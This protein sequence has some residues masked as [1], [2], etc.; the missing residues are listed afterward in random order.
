MFAGLPMDLLNVEF[1]FKAWLLVLNCAA[2]R[3]C[4]NLLKGWED[5]CVGLLS[6]RGASIMLIKQYPS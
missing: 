6:S 4:V 3:S 1:I 2:R 5:L